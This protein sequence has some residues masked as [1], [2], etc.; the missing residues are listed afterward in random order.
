MERK[1]NSKSIADRTRSVMIGITIVMVA[2]LAGW[3]VYCQLMKGSRVSQKIPE[4]ADVKATEKEQDTGENEGSQADTV[5]DAS[6]QANIQK[7]GIQ[8][9]VVLSA[10]R[11]TSVIYSQEGASLTWKEEDG[12]VKYEI[13][14]KGKKGRFKKIGESETNNY[15]DTAIKEQK[16]YRYKVRAVADDGSKSKFCNVMLYYHS[17]IDKEKPM[18]A[19]TFDDGPSMYTKDILKV[20][21]KYDARATFFIVG[22][23][24]D[25]YKDTM[26][27]ADKQ[28]CEIGS[29]SYSHANLGTAGQSVINAQLK[30]TE[31]KVKGVLGFGTPV[32]RPPYGSIGTRLKKTVGKPMILWS[33]DTLDWKT[34]NAK[35]TIKS[36]MD[37]VQDGDIILMHDLYEATRDAV[38]KIVPTLK[39]KGYQM[40]TVSEM[41]YYKG[42]NLKDG[43]AYTDIRNVKKV[44]KK[45]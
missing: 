43:V 16:Q 37:H 26:E 14:R 5:S 35:S 4:T 45:K 9:E 24:V 29:H 34:R 19:L 25:S 32:M 1:G 12:V 13:F 2:C 33:I 44:N 27:Q 18:V 10:P 23:R 41:A 11:K 40:V 42:A 28:G 6:V 15:L 38:K 36:I 7:A 22:Q 3:L 21:K 8:K 39:K 31:K 30:K 17:N 20:L